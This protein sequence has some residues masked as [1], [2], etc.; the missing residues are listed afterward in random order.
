ML[1]FDPKDWERLLE[2]SDTMLMSQGSKDPDAFTKAANAF[3]E[4]DTFVRERSTSDG[5]R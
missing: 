4:W 2:W 1:G 3:A 5:G